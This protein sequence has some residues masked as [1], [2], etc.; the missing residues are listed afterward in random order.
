MKFAFTAY[1]PIVTNDRIGASKMANGL[2]E[3]IEKRTGQKFILTIHGPIDNERASA[4]EPGP[5][6]AEGPHPG[7]DFPDEADDD[8]TAEPP[9][10]APARRVR[11]AAAAPAE[12]AGDGE[13]KR[14]RGRPPGSGKAAG[15]A[16]GGPE[17]GADAEHPGRAPE[18]GRGHDDGRTAQGEGQERRRA[19][20]G[21]RGSGASPAPAERDR[22]SDPGEA[23]VSEADEWDDAEPALVL[24]DVTRAMTD[25]FVAMGG[26]AAGVKRKDVTKVVEDFTGFSQVKDIPDEAYAKTI[27]MLVRERKAYESGKKTFSR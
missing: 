1:G 2:I 19:D 11:G 9:A 13:P 22:G 26:E 14:R 10:E 21:A 16:P 18:G 12:P 23:G 5:A 27:T 4:P 17:Q 20:E 3:E 8:G 15:K 6:A 7:D 24:S 25:L